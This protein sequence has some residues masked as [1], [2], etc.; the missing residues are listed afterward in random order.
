[1]TSMNQVGGASLARN[2]AVATPAVAPATTARATAQGGGGADAGLAE[3]LAKLTDAVAALQQALT[4][5]GTLGGGGVTPQQGCG[6]ACGGGAA[7]AAPAARDEAP[8]SGGGGRAAGGEQRN[9]DRGGRAEGGAGNRGSGNSTRGGRRGSSNQTGGGAPRPSGG[10][11]RSPRP[12]GGGGGGGSTSAGGADGAPK[13]GSGTAP[14]GGVDSRRRDLRTKIADAQKELDKIEQKMSRLGR[15]LADVRRSKEQHAGYGGPDAIAYNRA[16]AREKEIL[17]ELGAL[18]N[19][20][21][22][23]SQSIGLWN[24]ELEKLS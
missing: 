11:G 15:E 17:A 20:G 9:G 8:V 3:L 13:P 5:A 16:V 2:P 23:L 10:G 4:S 7:P 24:Q 6:S 21:G 1:M 14:S 19:A 22:Y 12:S 18:R